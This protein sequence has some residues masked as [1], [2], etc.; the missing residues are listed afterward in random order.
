ME[1]LKEHG[2]Q[3]LFHVHFAGAQLMQPLVNLPD[4]L[5]SNLWLYERHFLSTASAGAFY[6]VP[7]ENSLKIFVFPLSPA[8]RWK[9][10]SAV[11]EGVEWKVHCN[12]LSSLQSDHFKIIQV[13]S[14]IHAKTQTYWLT[15]SAAPVSNTVMSL[16]PEISGLTH[17]R[18]FW[19]EKP[20]H[21][22]ATASQPTKMETHQEPAALKG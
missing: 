9:E 19:Q 10:R 16:E 13:Y 3:Q 4:I 8:P 7:W 22:W 2:G 1:A 11:V 15:L 18:V 12:I 6:M 5:P 17:A 21:S 14:F 20:S